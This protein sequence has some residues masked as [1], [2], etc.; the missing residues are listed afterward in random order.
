MNK[1]LKKIIIERIKVMSPDVGISMGLN[2]R[3]LM[4][5]EMLR[6]IKLNTLVGDK[7]LRIQLKYLMALK[8][9]VV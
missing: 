6:E 4:R 9:C 2:G 3:F 5:D 1:L 8:E 7:I